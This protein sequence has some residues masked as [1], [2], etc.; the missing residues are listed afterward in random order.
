MTTSLTLV[1]DIMDVMHAAFDPAFGEA[2]NRRQ[3]SDALAMPSTHALIIDDKGS[4]STAGG[5]P[6]RAAGFSLTRAAADEEELLLIAVRP[7]HRGQGLGSALIS[8]LFEA[9]HARGTRRLFLEMRCDNPAVHLYRTAGFEPVGRRLAYYQQAD[10][11]R[12]DAI[13]FAR[14]L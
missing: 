11:S 4:V 9:A 2:W 3:V 8:K 1:D 6:A 5:C 10:G 13:T 12:A 14:S 7:E